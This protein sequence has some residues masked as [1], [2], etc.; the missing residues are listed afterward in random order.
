MDL[1]SVREVVDA[2][3]ALP[4]QTGDAWL[5]GGTALFAEPRPEVMRLRD[6]TAMEWPAWEIMDDGLVIAATCTVAELLA[7]A[8]APAG[9]WPQARALI[10]ACCRA[11]SSS[12]KVWN[13]A[14]VGG[15]L[16]VALPAGPM[17][18]MA[19]ALDGVCRVLAVN[20]R[21]RRV[22]ATGFVT[23]VGR[24]VLLPG[25][26]LRSVT[27][28]VS[29]L[30]KRTAVG[31]VSLR[32]GGRSAALV[33]GTYAPETGRLGLAVTAATIRPVTVDFSHPPSS[34]ALRA[35]LHEMLDRDLIV[36]DVHG[37]PQWRRHM[38]TYLADGVRHDL[39]RE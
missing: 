36:D 16:C 31:R 25:E 21:E 14:T 6:L 9:P 24:T 30:A 15:N 28:P 1:P 20:G 17:I 33:T 8:Q 19:V 4:W 35:T 37:H 5:A 32:P 12:F 27:L 3:C 26:V 13:T 38:V 10:A 11:F 7:F 39:T 22:P 34:A 29:A 18:S 23:G 2:R